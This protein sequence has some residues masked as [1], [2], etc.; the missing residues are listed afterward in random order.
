VNDDRS[1]S[2]FRQSPHN[3]LSSEDID[4][5]KQDIDAIGAD[6][7]AFRFNEG[8]QTGFSDRDGMIN[9]R[10][11][12]FPDAAS[13]HPRDKLS[14]RAV[15]AHEY[16]G[17]YNFSPSSFEATDWRDEMRA[18]YVAALKAPNLT[19]EDRKYLM[20]DAYERAREAG[21][22]VD[23]SKKARELIYGR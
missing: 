13:T 4:S 19:D 2:G 1:A 8:R 6:P 11:D 15:L 9:V 20:L 10:G 22:C 21:H 3:T 23:Y 7:S 5:L 12:V 18:S 16:Y 17:H 14:A